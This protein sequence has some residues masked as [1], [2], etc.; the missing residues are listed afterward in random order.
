MS[1]SITPATTPEQREAVF[2]LRY[3]VLVEEARQTS[4]LADHQFRCIEEPMD[5][6]ARL[7]V[8]RYGD[9][10]VGAL[11]VNLLSEG[12]WGGEAALLHTDRVRDAQTHASAL[13]SLPLVAAGFRTSGV[14]LRLV[15]AAFHLNLEEGVT[16]DFV[17]VTPEH[18]RFYLSLGY[19]AY[20]GRVR[21]PEKGDV[22]PMVL[23]LRDRAY[24]A[25]INSPLA[26]RQR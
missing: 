15:A 19:R 18:E 22:L 4:A 1:L 5:V 14:P 24:F 12:D 21:H 10:V 17:A 3:A 16:H 8:A 2:R 7:L 20:C 6:T 26:G 25:E 13:S 9:T 11:R 23:A